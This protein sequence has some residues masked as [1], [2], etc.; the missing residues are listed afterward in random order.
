MDPVLE[1]YFDILV[2]LHEGCRTQISGMTQEE[3]DW[4]PSNDMNSLAVLVAHIAGA[5]RYWISDVVMGEAT[6]RDRDSEFA[7][8]GVRENELS[9]LLDSALEYIRKV[10]DNLSYDHLAEV[11]IS[12]RDGR[13]Y[14]V[15]WAIAHVLEHTALHLGQMQI[16]R[17][18]VKSQ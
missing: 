14:T 3:L 5:E 18:W 10:F 9:N 11:R 4:R 12:P 8:T 2:T 13:T 17:Q 15:A 6:G 7:T 16:T 1:P